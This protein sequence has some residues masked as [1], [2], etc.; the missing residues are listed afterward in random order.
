MSNLDYDVEK[1][2]PSS[3]E[4]LEKADGSVASFTELIAEGSQTIIVV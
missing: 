4:D 3:A 1:V 2:D